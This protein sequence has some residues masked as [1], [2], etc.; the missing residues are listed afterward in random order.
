MPLT[1]TEAIEQIKEG[2]VKLQRP[3]QIRTK[4]SYEAW[5]Y[6]VG[7]R[8]QLEDLFSKRSGKDVELNMQYIYGKIVEDWCRRKLTLKD[9]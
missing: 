5:R 7:Q 1:D 6:S 8:H 3:R 4:I 9:L 2:C